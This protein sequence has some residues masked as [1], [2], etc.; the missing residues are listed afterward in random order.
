M[1]RAL[2]STTVA[3][4][5]LALATS[6]S[7]AAP[8]KGKRPAKPKLPP[9]DIELDAP[10]P[11]RAGEA[12]RAVAAG[13][14]VDVTV[15]EVAGSQAYLK[16]GAA[17]GV[18]RGAQVTIDRRSFVV[19]EATASYAVV[20][21]GERPLREHDRGVAVA[22]SEDS[23]KGAELPP[24]KPEA[25]FAG[26]WPEPTP[27][28]DAQSP[29]YVPLGGGER[30]SR[31]DVRIMALFGGVA[32]LGERGSAISRAEL[33]ARVHA[34]P[35]SAPLAFDLDASLQ[36]WIA[37]DLDARAGSSA[38][39][40]LRVREMFLQY[41]RPAGFGVGLGRMR[42]AAS[43][44]GTLDG[45]RV[46]VPVGGGFSVGAFGGLLPNPLSSAPTLD[47]Q[48]FGVETAYSAPESSLRPEAALVVH[49]STFQGSLDE[50]RLSG[51]VGLFPGRS[52][53][54][55][56]FEVSNFDSNNPWGASSIELTTAGVDTSIRSGI[57]QAGARLDLRQPVRSR[58]LASFLPADWFC[59][60]APLPAGAPAAPEPC[61]G[62]VSTRGLGAVDLGLE[63]GHFAWTV[64]GT[65][66]RDLTE[67]AMPAMLGGMST[68]RVVRIAGHGRADVT[69]HYARWD[70]MEMRG[71]MAG[72]G[73]SLFADM[74][75]VSVYYRYLATSYR[76]VPGTLA[77][78]G[79]G[80]ALMLIPSSTLLFTAQGEAIHGDD[81][82][83]LMMLATAMWRPRF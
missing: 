65:A 39:P 62:S 29:R 18:R 41:G 50:R 73:V 71:L 7:L 72:P 42:Y 3:V 46:R 12:P 68:V 49:G 10:A 56:H 44:L 74:L 79:A 53:V 8:R 64:G 52:R 58:W 60:T 4:L 67:R 77:Q 13:S 17:A 43:T 5:A 32:P 11:P 69:G 23:D 48:R 36:R 19:T 21:A 28:A 83:A 63:A 37:T 59:R 1:R 30:D 57:F 55:G 14:S 34:E 27:P 22:V 31:Y 9:V 47:A 54:G 33:N 26:V 24:V 76:S 2:L 81:T 35:F 75:D 15:I 40:L 61:A 51:V 20:D 78:H 70:S 66:I 80:S 16:P 25:A 38:R 6:T 45:T 82:N